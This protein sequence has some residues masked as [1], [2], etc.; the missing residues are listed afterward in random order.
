MK[1]AADVHSAIMAIIDD[2]RI[3]AGKSAYDWKVSVRAV[4]ESADVIRTIPIS[5]TPREYHGAVLSRLQEL[6]DSYYDADGEYTSGRSD[7]G[8]IISRI[9][10]L[11][12]SLANLTD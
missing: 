12:N 11:E 5:G 7:I 1:I 2:R 6:F 8:T 9:E 3:A 10:S 4:A